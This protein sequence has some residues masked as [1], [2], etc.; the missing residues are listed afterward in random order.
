[1]NQPRFSTA[2]VGCTLLF[3][4]TVVAVELLVAQTAVVQA[5]IR[6]TLLVRAIGDA[7]QDAFS[8]VTKWSSVRA[9]STTTAAPIV[10]AALSVAVRDAIGFAD[11]FIANGCDLRATPTT[12]VAAVIAAFL[13]IAFWEALRLAQA[14]LTNGNHCRALAAVSTATIVSALFPRTV[15]NTDVG[16]QVNHRRVAG[17]ILSWDFCINH[18]KENPFNV[19]GTTDKGSQSKKSKSEVQSCMH[20]EA[21]RFRGQITR[22]CRIF[23]GG[24]IQNRW[25]KR[26]L[27]LCLF[28]CLPVKPFVG[29]PL[30]R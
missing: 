30:R 13:V 18:V 11:S 15:G 2:F 23:T 5:S 29:A 4:G 16:G 25:K 28:G 8:F 20:R 7:L 19:A 26:K 1:L 9:D 6:A 27:D 3:T 21:S 22:F 17:S 10:A 14:F 24:I 12:A